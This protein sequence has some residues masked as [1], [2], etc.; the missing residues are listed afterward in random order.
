[1][2]ELS[3]GARPRFTPVVLMLFVGSGCAALIYEVVWFHLLRLVVGGSAVSLGFLLGSFMGG[4]GLGSL[5]LPRL[6]PARWHPLRV[7]AVL[8]LLIGVIGWAMPTL[9]PGVG[10][11]YSQLVGSW[12]HSVI[13]RGVV[14]AVVL[15]PP[16]VLMGATLPAIARW[17]DTSRAGLSAMGRFYAANLVGAVAGTLLAGFYLL[18]VHD[19]VVA[20]QVAVWINGVIAVAA[21]L[22]AGWR[23]FVPA[24]APDAGA[25]EAP[26]RALSVHAAI[27]LSGFTALGAEVVWTRL[28]S[29]LLGASVYTFSLI[30]AVFLVGLG[31]GSSFGARLA[32]RVRDPRVWFGVCQVL[33]VPAFVYSAWMITSVLPWIEPTRVLQ[34]RVYLSTAVRYPY[35]FVRCALA[36]LPGPLL[37]GASFPLAI[38]SAGAG[39]RDPGRLVGGISAA[40]T[41]GA[42]AGALGIS[43]GVQLL[44]GSQR[45]Q[46]ILAVAA[47]AAAALLF[48]T[49]PARGVFRRA[50]PAVLCLAIAPPLVSRLAAV[51]PGLIASGRTIG[52]WYGDVDYLL[53]REGLSSSVAVTEAEDV[54]SFHVC[55]KVEASSQR[56]DMRLQ[57]MLGHL[58]ALVHGAPRSVL[59]VGCGAGVTAGCFVDHP[60][61][62]R[63]VVCEIEPNVIEAAREWFADENH[64]VLRDPRTEVV[65]DDARH[66]MLTTSEKFDII[67]SDPIHPWVRG[68]AALYSIDY[69]HLV[70]QRLNPGAVV[71]QW[72]PLYE[73]D[74]AAV[75]SQMGT[76]FRA[77]PAG[78]VWN[79]DLEEKGY[80]TVL[81]ARVDPMRI[82]VDAVAAYLDSHHDVR[83]ALDEVD[84]GSAVAV[85]ST[86]AGRAQDLAPWLLDAQI[87]DDIGLKLQYLAGLRL[88][89][90]RDAQIYGEIKRHCVFPEG[91]FTASPAL[92]A[93]LRRRLAKR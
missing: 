55:G 80:D 6:L 48:V 72:V 49:A 61:V 37:W 29:L 82:D 32:G 33:L 62:E 10:R 66:F 69:F 68:A 36:I 84:L 44:G 53:V 9:L 17:L 87:N 4:M 24:P 5:L 78:T 65:F 28:L 22:L 42:I 26:V 52:D 13:L 51:P 15:L 20:S 79:S 43:L 35:D 59:I 64:D 57:R 21:L 14:C 77:F 56:I 74:E 71:T 83:D 19:A 88:D 39:H 2:S 34:E 11:A 70:K 89:V 38:A 91:L 85:L 45:E 75:K 60:S 46:Q 16:T 76:F 63:I 8:E 41:L 1:M 47:A 25:S 92:E 54:R 3:S 12:G 86:Y 23:R 93:E 30:L 58:P 90:F 67:T 73:T 81:M 7:Y 27:A 18:R 31:V 50:L 40:N